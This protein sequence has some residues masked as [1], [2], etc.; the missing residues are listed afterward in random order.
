M[1]PSGCKPELKLP[2]FQKTVTFPDEN[3]LDISVFFSW[4]VR[5][6][7]FVT[8][9][10]LFLSPHLSTPPPL[11]LSPS[12]P[13]AVSTLSTVLFPNSWPLSVSPAASSRLQDPF[14]CC[15]NRH[16]PI[17]LF[18]A[19]VKGQAFLQTSTQTRPASASET[20][21]VQVS[22]TWSSVMN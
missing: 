21:D 15:R 2:D 1:L 7:C 19:V 18:T 10:R 12:L 6:P 16:N 3:H 13:P 22:T 17:S 9:E 11:H 20:G 14:T 4:F 8:L 5:G